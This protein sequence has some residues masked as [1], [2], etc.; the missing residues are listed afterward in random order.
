[1]ATIMLHGQQVIAVSGA[2]TSPK[3]L[4]STSLCRIPLPDSAR[5]NGYLAPS[6]QTLFAE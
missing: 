1:M 6:T 4:C 3:R 5:K 2:S